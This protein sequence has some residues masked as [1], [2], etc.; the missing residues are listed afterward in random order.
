MAEGKTNEPG[1]AG[2]GAPCGKRGG[3]AAEGGQQRG[4]L[5]LALARLA[6]ARLAAL[7]LLAQPKGLGK[8][9]EAQRVV[10]QLGVGVALVHKRQLRKQEGGEG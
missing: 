9:L 2:L 10:G 7:L 8:L 6:L 4:L 1:L 3:S 5:A